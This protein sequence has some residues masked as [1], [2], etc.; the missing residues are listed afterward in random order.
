MGA[1][2]DGL[3]TGFVFGDVF[4][5]RSGIFFL[6]RALR[7]SIPSYVNSS[8]AYRDLRPVP[9]VTLK[10]RLQA[11][12]SKFELQSDIDDDSKE[13]PI[14]AGAELTCIGL[15]EVKESRGAG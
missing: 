15:I 7:S 2:Y 13:Q 9:C 8:E 5:S 1:P 10:R 14:E 6:I 3:P 12:N 4:P 11:F